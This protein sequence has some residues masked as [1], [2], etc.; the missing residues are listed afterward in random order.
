MTSPGKNRLHKAPPQ[1]E[2]GDLKDGRFYCRKIDWWSKY[3][4]AELELMQ[5]RGRQLREGD[6]EFQERGH[7]Q[8]SMH[9][10]DR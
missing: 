1:K 7:M 2:E 10:P 6:K 8:K 4:D 5:R 9:C 3:S